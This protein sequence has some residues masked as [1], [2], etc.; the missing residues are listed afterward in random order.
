MGTNI[1]TF[2]RQPV[3]RYGVYLRFQGQF[4]GFGQI[5]GGNEIC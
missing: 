4:Q 5:T 1:T 3:V 2:F